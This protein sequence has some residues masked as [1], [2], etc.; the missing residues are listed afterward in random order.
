M[1]TVSKKVLKAIVREKGEDL[2]SPVHVS[3]DGGAVSINLEDPRAVTTVEQAE[4]SVRSVTSIL[5]KVEHIVGT[6]PVTVSSAGGSMVTVTI[7]TF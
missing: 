6:E 4:A 5:H 7:F 2:T 1:R 3:D